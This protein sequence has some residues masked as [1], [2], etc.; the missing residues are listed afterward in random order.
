MASVER[1]PDAGGHFGPYGGRFVPETLIHAL[2]ELDAE[3]ARARADA[4]FARALDEEGPPCRYTDE[5]LAPKINER[6][7]EIEAGTAK[8]VDGKQA[9]E[10]IRAELRNR[11]RA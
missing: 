2:D 5:E 9:I 3:Y 10:E 8:L 1:V 4:E 11:R 6:I 7:A